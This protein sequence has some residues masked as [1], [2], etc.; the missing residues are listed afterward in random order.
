M[1]K[2]IAT[3]IVASAYRLVEDVI[4]NDKKSFLNATLQT[5]KEL[6]EIVEYS[7]SIKRGREADKPVARER[8]ICRAKSHYSAECG[9]LSHRAARVR[10]K[11]EGR[12]V[13]RYSRGASAA[14]SARNS[15][16]V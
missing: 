9:R 14:A 5:L 1:A 8:R 7:D 11:R 16:F 4:E 3:T 15:V 12:F 13:R 6:T 10:A 2:K